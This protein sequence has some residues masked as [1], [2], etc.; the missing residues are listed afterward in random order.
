MLSRSLLPL[1]SAII[2]PLFAYHL[3]ISRSMSD[4]KKQLFA[5][6]LSDYQRLQA[7]EKQYPV[8]RDY[9]RDDV[10]FELTRSKIEQK[11]AQLKAA[12]AAKNTTQAPT[13]KAPNAAMEED[14][15]PTELY[16]ALIT[17]KN[18]EINV[19]NAVVKDKGADKIIN[20][21]AL[22]TSI[23][24]DKTVAIAAALNKALVKIPTPTRNM[25]LRVVA[26]EYIAALNSCIADFEAN[27]D[28]EQKTAIKELHKADS[29][30][31][32]GMDATQLT[33]HLSPFTPAKWLEAAATPD[34]TQ[35]AFDGWL[36]REKRWLRLIAINDEVVASTKTDKLKR[37]IEDAYQGCPQTVK[38]LQTKIS[39]RGSIQ[40]VAAQL[41]LNLSN[42]QKGLPKEEIAILAKREQDRT[43]SLAASLEACKDTNPSGMLLATAIENSYSLAKAGKK[44]EATNSYTDT[45]LWRKDIDSIISDESLPMS[46]TVLNF[47]K[48]GL[49]FDQQFVTYD[50]C[51]T[52]LDRAMRQAL[53]NAQLFG[54]FANDKKYELPK[55]IPF[56]LIVEK[57]NFHTHPVTA[58]NVMKGYENWAVAELVPAAAVP[59]SLSDTS[60]IDLQVLRAELAEHFNQK[61]MGLGLPEKVGNFLF[62]D[63]L[64]DKGEKCSWADIKSVWA[65]AC[66]SKA[67]G[68]KSII[69][70]IAT[71][72]F[73]AKGQIESFSV[74]CSYWEVMLPSKALL[75]SALLKA[76]AATVQ[77]KAPSKDSSA[78]HTHSLVIAYDT[79]HLSIPLKLDLEVESEYIVSG[80]SIIELQMVSLKGATLDG[81]M[82]YTPTK[83]EA[84]NADIVPSK[85]EFVDAESSL[86]SKNLENY[87]DAK[88]V[89]WLHIRLK[90]EDSLTYGKTINHAS[91]I[92]SEGKNIDSNPIQS[93]AYDAVKSWYDL[94]AGIVITPFTEGF[95]KTKDNALDAGGKVMK[96]TGALLG[97]Y[98]PKTSSSA[99]EKSIEEVNII[100]IWL[101]VQFTAI[102]HSGVNTA[103]GAAIAILN[104]PK[105]RSN[106]T[107][108]VIAPY[109]IKSGNTFMLPKK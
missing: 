76:H 80:D 12:Q 41:H 1:L 51:S 22:E 103:P 82:T 67:D 6:L 14:L 54:E 109:S 69:E 9:H 21:A 36:Y 4:D 73:I 18:K 66:T 74:F 96:G 93:T 25:A 108:F 49:S 65:V 106:N 53:Q 60:K 84:F 16:D 104:N 92:T 94:S 33:E 99:V 55:S 59:S 98:T 61:P 38:I 35:A 79:L 48:L 78:K 23:A 87:T 47:V 64:K 24:H 56:I 77:K 105:A 2:I 40:I 13:L 62:L 26:D 43:Q 5:Q 100:E 45:D 29:K 7:L 81:Y 90:V 10:D 37:D 34:S 71:A 46:K 32:N 52:K 28:K 68:I 44:T 97:G 3:I 15:N 107:M 63:P 83:N 95:E 101:P 42:L 8:L 50:Q 86:I 27:Q 17:W 31:Y 72:E 75:H 57:L 39:E 89:Q 11:I 19:I 58:S 91:S 30:R 85:L 88:I 70:P 20:T 102:G